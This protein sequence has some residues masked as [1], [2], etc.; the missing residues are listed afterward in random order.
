M[1][2]QCCRGEWPSRR[3]ARRISGTAASVL[4]GALLLLLPK[5]PMCLAARFTVATGMSISAAAAARAR[6]LIV[7][8]GFMVAALVVVEIFRHRALRPRSDGKGS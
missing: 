1:T 5:C 7:V 8:L 6:G 3:L 4:P 2:R